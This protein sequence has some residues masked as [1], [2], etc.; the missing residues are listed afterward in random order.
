MV[1]E[2]KIKVGISVGDLNGIGGE[3]ILKTFEDIRIL[4]LCTP[5]V[6]ASVKTMS[7]FKK[8]LNINVNLHGI[9]NLDKVVHGKI[10]VLNVWKEGVD[11]NYGQNDENVGQYAIKSFVAEPD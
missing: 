3:I 1:K 7:F 11:I 4:E 2:E 5:I 10:N 8:H 9:D 6:F